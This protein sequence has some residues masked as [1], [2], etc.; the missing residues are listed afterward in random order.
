MKKQSKKGFNYKSE[1]QNW[2]L[3]GKYKGNKNYAQYQKSK[4]SLSNQELNITIEDLVKQFL[5]NGGKVTQ[6]PDKSA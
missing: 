5:S 6:C 2:K 1:A 3:K 4:R